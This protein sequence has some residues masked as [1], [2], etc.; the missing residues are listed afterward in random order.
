MIKREKLF[1]LAILTFVAYNVMGQE[2][3]SSPLIN[4]DGSVVFK[5]YSPKAEKVLLK[6]SFIPKSLPIKTP[7]GVFGKDG[8]YEME[9]NNGMW[10]YTTTPLESE[11]YTYYF[12]V[13]DKRSIDPNNTDSVRDVDT[14]YSYFII[15]N[16]IADNYIEQDVP[17]GKVSKVWYDSSITGMPK[18]RMSVYTPPGYK[19]DSKVDYPVLYLLHGSGGDENSWLEMGKAAEILDNMI[20]KKEC[21]PMIVVMPNGIADMEAAPGENPYSDAKAKGINIESMLGK[22]EKAFVP[23]IVTYVENN[24]RVLKNKQGRAI[25]G[26]S[27]GGLHTIYI[28]ANNPDMFDYVGLFSA[29]TTNTLNNKKIKKVG[30]IAKGIDNITSSVPF[31]GKGK[32]GKKLSSFKD[33]IDSGELSIYEDIDKKLKLQFKKPPKLYYIAVGRDD[34]VK[35]IND[36]YR[37]KLSDAGYKYTYHETDGGHTWEN[38]RKY[39]VDF[40]PRLFN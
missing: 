15:K 16:G 30:K 40:L 39:L 1:V 22:I 14:Y 11:M 7:A 19:D 31:L 38:W 25:A 6:G 17:H 23:D 33:G 35:K 34:F 5:F 10:T 8:H 32:L 24:Y 12:E 37:L 26:L 21:V 36:D 27:L 18:R 3:K 20:A 2:A 4:E 13:D 28:T 29:Q 9:N